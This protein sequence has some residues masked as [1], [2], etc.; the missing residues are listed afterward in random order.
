[1]SITIGDC[2]KRLRFGF[3]SMARV[4]KISQHTTLQFISAS[5]ELTVAGHLLTTYAP[6]YS[7][8]SVVDAVFIASCKLLQIGKSN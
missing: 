6:S 5:R 4:I 3:I 1:M 7:D 8:I 2:P